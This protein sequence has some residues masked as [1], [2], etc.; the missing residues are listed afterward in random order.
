MVLW[1]LFY[2]HSSQHLVIVWSLPWG[3]TL[4]QPRKEH[5]RFPNPEPA[6][7]MTKTCT[8]IALSLLVEAVGI[9]PSALAVDRRLPF[10]LAWCI[11]GVCRVPGT[12]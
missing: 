6:L 4:F 10:T 12:S 5:L 3:I 8:S 7:I 9:D 1:H 2:C 11:A